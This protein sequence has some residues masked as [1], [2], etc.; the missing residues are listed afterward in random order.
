M[1]VK[2][3]FVYKSTFIRLSLVQKI[4]SRLQIRNKNLQ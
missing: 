3:A 2:I 4:Q 1:T